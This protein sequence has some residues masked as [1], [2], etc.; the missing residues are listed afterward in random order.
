VPP[1]IAARLVR[2]LDRAP[3][4][5]VTLIDDDMHSAWLSTFATWVT[6]TDPVS[7]PAATPSSAST[8]TTS[9]G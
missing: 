7:R 5:F 9:S 4:T 3:S 1:E 2:A 8:P 6:G